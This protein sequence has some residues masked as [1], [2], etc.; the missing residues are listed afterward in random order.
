VELYLH[1]PI[2]PHGV[3]RQPHLYISGISLEALKN[4][5]NLL[6]CSGGDLNQLS[7]NTREKRF[8]F[9]QFTGQCSV[10][11]LIAV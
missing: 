2:R 3:Y 1:F 6:G 8:N 4:P 9:D 10:F 11:V 7:P 5:M